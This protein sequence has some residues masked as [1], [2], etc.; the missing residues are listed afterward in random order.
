M[1]FSKYCDGNDDQGS[2]RI[3]TPYN[4][5]SGINSQDGFVLDGT[6]TGE[7]NMEG[8]GS[9]RGNY[10]LS[11]PWGDQIGSI[12]IHQVLKDKQIKVDKDSYNTFNYMGEQYRYRY[13][14][15]GDMPYPFTNDYDW[16]TPWNWKK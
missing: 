7:V 12:D 2:T 9:Q 13:I 3:Y 5:N 16:E 1:K 11:T 6:T 4:D 14:D 8:N 15:Q 10:Q